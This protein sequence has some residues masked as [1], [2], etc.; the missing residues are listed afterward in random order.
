MKCNIF[1]SLI[2]VGIFS[3][4]YSIANAQITEVSTSVGY[5]MHPMNRSSAGMNQVVNQTAPVHDIAIGFKVFKSPFRFRFRFAYPNSEFIAYKSDPFYN[6]DVREGLLVGFGLEKVIPIFNYKKHKLSI[7][8]G[9]AYYGS[10]I[11]PDNATLGSSFIALTE[12]NYRS[13]VEI[14]ASQNDQT[15]EDIYLT[16]SFNYSYTFWRKMK[17]GLYAQYDYGFGKRS[18]YYLSQEVLR[19]E[20]AIDVEPINLSVQKVSMLRNFLSFGF[21]IG[22]GL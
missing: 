2:A 15:S 14:N 6:I 9:I 4:N 12:P 8:S 21:S 11:D 19:S 16:N 18:D 13:V 22:V 5:V 1:A 17:I 7:N 3:C 10:S 20:G